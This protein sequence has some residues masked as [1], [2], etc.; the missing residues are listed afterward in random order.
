MIKRILF[1][2]SLFIG[3]SAFGQ[4]NDDFSDGDFTN[5]VLWTGE[6]GL[7]E[8]D[9]NLE[10]HLN[11]PAVSD[12]AYL[13]TSSQSI[14]NASW[15]F[16]L[17]LDFN[18]SGSNFADVYLLSNQS[19]LE[20]S[21]DGY[22]VRIGNSEDEVSLYRQD[23]NSI[24]EIIDGTDDLTD[25]SIVEIRILVSRDASGNWELLADPTGGDN[26]IS[27]GTV[28]DDTH[29]S[30]SF[31][32]VKCTYTSTRSDKFY[33]DEFVVSGDGFMDTQAP[34]LEDIIVI[35]NQSLRLIFNEA[36]DPITAQNLS[37]YNVDQGI[38]N[39]DNVNQPS[40][41]FI[42]LSFST[43]FNN[44]QVYNIDVSG[45]ADLS[46]NIITPLSEDFFFFFPGTAEVGDVIINEIFADPSPSQGLPELE[47][48]EIF[49]A[50]DEV[51]DLQDWVYVNSSTERFLSSFP[52]L[53]G[54][55]VI[56]C[57]E[58]DESQ[59]LS[60]GDVIGIDN[61]SALT[62]TGDSLTLRSNTGLVIDIVSYTDDW[63]QNEQAAMGGF[64]LER[65]NPNLA[66]SGMNNWI[67]STNP[68][69][70]T[71]GIQNSVLNNIEDTSPPEILTIDIENTANVIL[72]FNEPMDEISLE[73]GTY[74]IDNGVE[75]IGVNSVGDFNDRIRL[76]FSP[77]LD[78]TL[79][80]TITVENVFDCEGNDIGID[81]IEIQLGFPP[82]FGD[83]IISEI[84]SDPSPSVG[85]PEAEYVEIYNASDRLIN[86]SNCALDDAIIPNN[87][88]IEPGQY[89]ILASTESALDFF[90]FEDYIGLEPWSSV[91]LTNSGE[92]LQFRNAQDI[93]INQVTYDIDTHESNK[94]E[95]GWSL[96]IKNLNEICRG[97][98][99][100]A[101]SVN[102]QGGTPGVQNSVFTEIADSSPPELLDIRIIDDQNISLLFNE[103]IDSTNIF[104]LTINVDNGLSSVLST[105]V[106]PTYDR[107]DILLAPAM[108][109]GI[110]YNIEINGLKDC[111]GNEAVENNTGRFG[112][113]EEAEAGDIIINEIL[114]NPPEGASDFIEIYNRSDKTL[115]LQN[116]RL[117]NL[118]NGIPGDLSVIA[119]DGKLIF[120][121]EFLALSEDISALENNYP[122]GNPNNYFRIE[123]APAYG[124][125][126]GTV[127]L[128]MPDAQISDEFSYQ[129]E[130]HFSL[131]DDVKG[132]SLERIDF[133]RITNDP[134]NWH[135]ASSIEGFATPGKAN[136]QF[137][138]GSIPESS[139]QLEP[140]LFSPDN[141]GFEDFL[142]INYLFEEPGFLANITIF[143]SRGALIN[144]LLQNELMGTT[145]I[146][147]WDGS[148]NDNT[149]AR[150]GVY[151]IFV[152]IFDL[153][154]N[155]SVFKKTCVVGSR[156]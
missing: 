79:V 94:R 99:N 153:E 129:E 143:D 55:Y 3:L 78:P 52:L 59:F 102:F 147:K 75:V 133:D 67:A 85:L 16:F 86:I 19:N 113:P 106:S 63:Y 120:P 124:N 137:F 6:S 40:A 7:F 156:F 82:E 134:S 84:M 112:L 108:N 128:L 121:Q 10:L 149:K 46:A 101:S 132:V 115:S 33:F 87:T 140:E 77:L 100:W 15:E 80:Y 96:E 27:Q 13:S 43:A 123:N 81:T 148:T 110:I 125:T 131:I 98:S 39:P 93:L 66:C 88:F 20:E 38:G 138:Q 11:A 23:G 150:V 26:Y 136:S 21:L 1:V 103:P 44:G 4:F 95:G 127:F 90:T 48:I 139:I 56:L 53:Q 37:N 91:F 152:E 18:P 32:G 36:I 14:N 12:I 151:V 122:N 45:L 22:F 118:D 64:S 142:N 111:V 73:F 57:D 116:W 146:V 126:E 107:L 117:G 105:L 114:F 89:K 8:V 61:F 154:G 24:N 31:F 92:N 35:T 135:S 25:A 50:G 51:Y 74:N 29:Q 145:G 119:Q 41:N 17:R 42:D 141:D 155:L 76:S 34:V 97:M 83:I 30:S 2:I 60:F 47:Y 62:N 68:N 104:S 58:E 109:S 9:P 71:P 70:G 69:G 54:Q 65:V 130:Y 5:D 144:N 72:I 49:N 28:N